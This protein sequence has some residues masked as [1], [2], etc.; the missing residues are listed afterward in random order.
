M[1]IQAIIYTLNTPHGSN[2]NSHHAFRYID[3]ET[4]KTVEGVVDTE[5]TA[6]AAMN[7]LFDHRASNYTW[8]AERF[9]IRVWKAKTKGWDFAGFTGSECAE[10][11]RARLLHKVI[12]ES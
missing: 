11:I 10:F 9:G 4:G 3:C 6:L 1:Q 7:T 8:F 12:K 2:G 5:G